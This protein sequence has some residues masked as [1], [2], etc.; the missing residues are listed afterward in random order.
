M[1]FIHHA[2]LS[3]PDYQRIRAVLRTMQEELDAELVLLIHRNGQQIA[4]EG[5]VQE[6]DLTALSSLAA[7]SLAATDGLAQLVGEKEFS[8]LFQQGRR[9]S[10]HISSLN[11]QF[12]LVLLF[13]E[14]VPPGLVRW[15]VKRA[16]GSLAQ[17]LQE[18]QKEAI[19]VDDEAG[20]VEGKPSPRYFT[21]ED[22]EKLFG[23]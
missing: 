22:I 7:A 4:N 18:Q 2:A 11:V 15:K 17:V 16:S 10:I 5:R 23:Q 1:S 9:R 20:V 21:D 8:V 6:L 3:E 19:V 12:C 13:D 14:R